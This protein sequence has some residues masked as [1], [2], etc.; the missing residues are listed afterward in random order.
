[1]KISKCQT[2]LGDSGDFFA[3]LVSDSCKVVFVA[4]KWRFP[5]VLLA[6]NHDSGADWLWLYKILG[7][8]FPGGMLEQ[9]FVLEI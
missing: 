8:F 6:I 9:R 2:L 4:S 5:D 3:L 1:M 7:V